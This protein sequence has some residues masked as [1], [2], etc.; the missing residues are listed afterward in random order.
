MKKQTNMK[1]SQLESQNM[2]KRRPS[3]R[4]VLAESGE[5]SAWITTVDNEGGSVSAVPPPVIEIGLSSSS[6]SNHIEDIIESPPTTPINP[7]AQLLTVP[8]LA[9]TGMK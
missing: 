6:S 1:L 2:L 5:E 4:F 3:K 9:K 8:Q 7:S